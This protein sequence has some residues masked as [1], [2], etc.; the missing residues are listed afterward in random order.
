MRSELDGPLEAVL[1]LSTL[2]AAE[3][4]RLR[5]RR[6]KSVDELEA[7]PVPT[8]RVSVVRPEPFGSREEAAGWL[9]E[10]RGDEDAVAA[11]LAAAQQVLNRALAARRAAAADPYAPDVSAARALV[12]R[13]GYGSGQA[14]TEGRHA[15][16]WELPR[17]G[18]RRARRSMAAARRAL[19]GPAGR[20]RASAAGRG[21]R[22]ARPRRPGRRPDPRRPPCE[23]RVALEALLAE[24]PDAA[25]LGEHRAAIGEAANAAL[26]G[27]LAPTE[28]ATLD[29]AVTAME[30]ALRRRA[31]S[32]PR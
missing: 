6:G 4:R 17:G 22:A 12:A 9:A 31:L 30:T 13:I 15:E 18:D 3:R 32:D 16:A 10:L 2:G 26:N 1:I 21:A 20:S 27:E 7:E 24:L 25:A 14:L 8:A 5:G 29:A 19:R 11:E 28:L 23:A